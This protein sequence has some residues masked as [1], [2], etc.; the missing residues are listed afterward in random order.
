MEN[1]MQERKRMESLGTNKTMKREFRIPSRT[2][3]QEST[4]D[5][6]QSLEY[7]DTAK[8]LFMKK[9]LLEKETFQVGEGFGPK[10]TP[11][12]QSK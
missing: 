10:R 1:A 3:T 5:S 2:E 9:K 6:R 4:C 8:N 11:R 7:E 12:S